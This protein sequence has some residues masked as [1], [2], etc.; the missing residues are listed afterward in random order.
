MSIAYIKEHKIFKLDTPDSTYAF[1]V[2]PTGFLLH[3]YYG[4]YVPDTD[5]AY[6]GEMIGVPETSAKVDSE[7]ENKLSL[8][9]AYLEYPCEGA[10]NMRISAL[11]IRGENRCNATDIRYKSHKIYKG[12]PQVQ[13][14]PAQPSKGDK[15]DIATKKP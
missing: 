1:R 9:A 10:G 8:D 3:L 6:L 13:V 11:S 15:K 7:E 5:L 2:S 4:A 14:L 12:K